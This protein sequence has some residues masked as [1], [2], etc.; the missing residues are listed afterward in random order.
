MK[1]PLPLCQQPDLQFAQE[2]REY[3]EENY[4]NQSGMAKSYWQKGF[5]C[6]L[7]IEGTEGYFFVLDDKGGA[8]GGY[9]EG[10][11]QVP[12]IFRFSLPEQWTNNLLTIEIMKSKEKS[13]CCGLGLELV[14]WP[15]ENKA[16]NV[17]AKRIAVSVH[18]IPTALLERTLEELRFLKE[19]LKLKSELENSNPE[20]KGILY[21]L[22]NEKPSV[23][24]IW[25]SG[26]EEPEYIAADAPMLFSYRHMGSVPFGAIGAILP[27][28]QFEKVKLDLK[29][30]KDSWTE[31]YY[32]A[33]VKDVLDY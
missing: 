21:A 30:I 31:L 6:W 17:M 23:I 22:D 15:N 19:P 1:I 18:E 12:S 2:L 32:P 24:R 16:A 28:S 25:G 8:K 7:P 4:K 20:L 26:D 33:R 14:F 9:A 5:C 10:V 11:K 29:K 3:R 27:D 13:K